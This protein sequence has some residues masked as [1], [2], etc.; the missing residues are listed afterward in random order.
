MGELHARAIVFGGGLDLV[1][2]PAEKK[3]FYSQ[4]WAPLTMAKFPYDSGWVTRYLGPHASQLVVVTV[5]ER[6]CGVRTVLESG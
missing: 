6:P 2:L 1:P 4:Y 3:L 5:R